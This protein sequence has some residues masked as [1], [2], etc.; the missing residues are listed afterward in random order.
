LDEFNRIELEVL[1]VI[2]QQMLCIIQAVQ[3]GVK[4]FVLEGTQLNLNPACYVCITMNPGYAGRSEL[5][6]NLKV[7]DCG[8]KDNGVYQHC[9][10]F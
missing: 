4:T 7:S 9:H 3:A 2:A 10:C 8:L 1:S 6:D 5:P